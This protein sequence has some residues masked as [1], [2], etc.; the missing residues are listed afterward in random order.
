MDLINLESLAL[1]V[2]DQML[3]DVSETALSQATSHNPER[4]IVF[5]LS[6]RGIPSL[7]EQETE[8]FLSAIYSDAPPIAR[9]LKAFEP[10]R[11]Q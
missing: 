5:R 10:S 3:R 1:P 11:H 7:N 9:L 2:S 4:T 8:R 6:G